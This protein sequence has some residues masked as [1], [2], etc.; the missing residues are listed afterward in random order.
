MTEKDA[1]VFPIDDKESIATTAIELGRIWRG[2]KI[3]LFAISYD[4]LQTLLLTPEKQLEEVTFSPAENTGVR[5]VCWNHV[6]TYPA[7][8]R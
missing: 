5:R 6:K 3:S 2:N 1:R 7:L 8:R 4:G